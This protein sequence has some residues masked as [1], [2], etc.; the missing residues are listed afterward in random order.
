MKRRYLT[1]AVL[2]A[3][4]AMRLTMLYDAMV[5]RL[6]VADQGFENKDLKVVNDNLCSV[7]E[8][9]LALRG[10]LRTDIWSGAEDLSAL[11]YA[12]H[13]ELVQANL[14]KD[15][16]RARKVAEVVG[17]LAQAWR[18]AAEVEAGAHQAEASRQGVMA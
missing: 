17:E 8:I 2:T 4:P 6:G 14:H 16:E 18:G 13:Q 9:L 10:T 5:L 3:S 1:E 15:R 12:L 7:Q 11:Y